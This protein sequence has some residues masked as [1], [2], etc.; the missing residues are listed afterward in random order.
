MPKMVEILGDGKT[1]A[2]GFLFFMLGYLVLATAASFP[3]L[4]LTIIFIGMGFGFTIP[5][6]NHMI[7]EVSTLKNQGKNLGLFSMGVFG[8]QFLSTFIEYIS[9][10]YRAIYGISSVLALLLGCG[11]YFM[12]QKLSKK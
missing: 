5:L 6:L 7:L 3:F 12:F 2:L 4:M 11:I 9:N 8:G 10:N 1:V